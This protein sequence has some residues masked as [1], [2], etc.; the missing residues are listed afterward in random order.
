M[1]RLGQHLLVGSA[2]FNSIK[3]EG[4][5]VLGEVLAK[6]LRLVSAGA[7]IKTW[8]EHVMASKGTQYG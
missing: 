8:P 5:S 6:M 7:G 2:V 4:S 1:P 3:S